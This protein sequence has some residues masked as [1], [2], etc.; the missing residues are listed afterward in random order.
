MATDTQIVN[1]KAI[2][3]SILANLFVLAR[4]TALFEG[5]CAAQMRTMRRA[6]SVNMGVDPALRPRFGGDC[7][8]LWGNLRTLP[9]GPRQ[10]LV[11]LEFQAMYA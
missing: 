11:Y 1:Q 7:P 4:C 9:V 2:T 5:M 3:L 8:A 10:N 6:R